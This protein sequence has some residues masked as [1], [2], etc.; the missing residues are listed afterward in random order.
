MSTEE[1]IIEGH[2]SAGTSAAAPQQLAVLDTDTPHVQYAVGT[3]AEHGLQVQIVDTRDQ[4]AAGPVRVADGGRRVSD[5]ASFI[6]ELRRRPLPPNTGTL[7]ANI[8]ANRVAAIYDDHNGPTLAANWR[9]DRLLLQLASDPDWQAWHALSG[10]WMR[11]AEFGDAI[12]EL[13]HTIT[14]PDQAELL[15]VIASIRASTKGNFE[16]THSRENGSVKL[17]YSQDVKASAGRRGELEVPEMIELSLTPWEGHSERFKV[18]A[19]FRF[20]V[21]GG[22]LRLCVKLKPTRQI[23]RRAWDNL[24]AFLSSELEDHPVLSTIDSL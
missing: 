17:T 12:E 10:K 11:Q 16:S 24:L 2:L 8:D 18:Q 3:T 14:R 9:E 4:F 7:W 15:E 22:D 1:P 20:T 5:A 6:T 13:L 21:D 19:Y 23:K